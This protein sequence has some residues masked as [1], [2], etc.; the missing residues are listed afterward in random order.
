MN[1]SNCGVEQ[2]VHQQH[3]QGERSS[4]YL[5]ISSS[6]RKFLCFRSWEGNEVAIPSTRSEVSDNRSP[7]TGTGVG[8]MNQ[9]RNNELCA[10]R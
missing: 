6:I 3:A 8:S 1:R 5:Q 4:T 7:W 2:E 9:Q 10:Q